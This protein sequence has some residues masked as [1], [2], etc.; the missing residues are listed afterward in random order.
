MFLLFYFTYILFLILLIYC[1]FTLFIYLDIFTYFK[2][3]ELLQELDYLLLQ[4]I[5]HLQQI[6]EFQ[7]QLLTLLLKEQN[8]PL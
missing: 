8:S 6:E 4:K 5:E 1:F 2:N 3:K 7:D